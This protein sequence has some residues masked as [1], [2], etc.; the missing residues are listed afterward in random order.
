MTNGHQEGLFPETPPEGAL[1]PEEIAAKTEHI[2]EVAQQRAEQTKQPSTS[3]EPPRM[4]NE[5]TERGAYVTVLEHHQALT[6]ALGHL[7]GA[8]MRAGLKKARDTAPSRR[9]ELARQQGS[10]AAL[11]GLIEGT[12]FNRIHDNERAYEAFTRA[13]GAQKIVDRGYQ[14]TDEANHDTAAYYSEFLDRYEGAQK[15]PVLKRDRDLFERTPEI[16][17]G[18]R[19]LYKPKRNKPSEELL[20]MQASPVAETP[21][22][23]TKKERLN[24]AK[25]AH[26]VGFIPKT[27]LEAG[28]ARA[29]IDW[30]GKP[31]G[32]MQHLQET[33]D[34]QVKIF[35]NREIR[36][37]ENRLI[38]T[39]TFPEAKAMGQDARRSK[40]MTYVNFRFNAHVQLHNLRQLMNFIDACPNP[41]ISLAEELGDA[42]ESEKV[43]AALVRF[44]HQQAVLND[45]SSGASFDPFHTTEDR[46]PEQQVSNQ[47]KVVEDKYTAS[48]PGE[49]AIESIKQ[50]LATTT[51]G[52]ARPIIKMAVQDEANR[53]RFW[54]WVYAQL[55]GR[56]KQLAEAAWAEY[57]ANLE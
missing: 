29:L 6:E 35:T 11:D 47:N 15:H 41:K 13:F 39:I 26:D 52:Q 32:V 14:S 12:E 37:D 46:R 17:T 27:Y 10:E 3:G 20:L 55:K 16:I 54:D 42:G 22:K 38:A 28:E 43:T 1:T 51:I 30:I 36:D 9:Q 24:L 49:D 7:A 31:N 40:V 53:T 48:E 56:E 25:I 50:W 33:Y 21:Q 44:A 57:A 34:R 19:R 18:D 4:P 23:L 45:K 8:S 5:A 2:A